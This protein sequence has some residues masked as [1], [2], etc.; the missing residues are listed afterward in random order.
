MSGRSLYPGPTLQVFP[1]ETLIVHLDNALTDLTIADYFSPEY[2]VAKGPVPIYPIQMKSS[3]LNLHVHGI[4]VSPKGNA[5][6]V[7]LHVPAGMS[8]T[9]TYEIAKNMPQGAYCITP[10]FIP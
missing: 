4:H 6:N 9:Y 3:P 2:T 1:G 7:M 10:T 5:D 8:N